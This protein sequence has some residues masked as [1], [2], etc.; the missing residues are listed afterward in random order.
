MVRPKSGMVAAMLFLAALAVAVLPSPSEV[1]V[2]M[3]LPKPSEFRSLGDDRFSDNGLILLR[4]TQKQKLGLATLEADQ[5]LPFDFSEVMPLAPSLVL[6]RGS[7]GW[8]LYDRDGE[9][10]AASSVDPKTDLE[11]VCYKVNDEAF[12][13]RTGDAEYAVYGR[14]GER[15]TKDYPSLRPFGDDSVSVLQNERIGV[16]DLKDQVVIPFEYTSVRVVGGKRCLARDAS[17][18]WGVLTLDGKTVLRF[19]YAGIG[20]LGRQRYVVANSAGETAVVTEA[21]DVIVGF[22]PRRFTGSNGDYIG[23]S[24]ADGTSSGIT[25]L[26]SGKMVFSGGSGTEGI[27]QLSDRFFV[28]SSKEVSTVSY[29]PSIKYKKLA[30]IDARKGSLTPMKYYDIRAVP[31]A[32]GLVFKLFDIEKKLQYYW[33][34]NEAGKMIAEKV[35]VGS[36]QDVGG[37]TLITTKSPGEVSDVT[38][39]QLTDYGAISYDGKPFFDFELSALLP[40]F[41]EGLAFVSSVRPTPRRGYIDASGTFKIENK[42]FQSGQ[43]FRG[44]TAVVRVGENFSDS[45]FGAIGKGGAFVIAPKFERLKRHPTRDDLFAADAGNGVWLLLD[46]QGSELHRAEASRI[47]FYGEDMFVVVGSG[48][49]EALM[50]LVGRPADLAHAQSSQ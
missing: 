31:S 41:S 29:N 27:Y 5:I 48:G 47:D 50:R 49:A 38:G 17:G 21:G 12:I 15:L 9:R 34:M 13:F 19:E 6:A 14:A 20:A 35:E 37:R 39:Y 32:D 24:S 2:V 40:E 22:A 4:D 11:E 3:R 46:R 1:E 45:R 23:W 43:P 33:L 18:K 16:V 25:D 36:V 42:D 30:L 10:V 26:Q 44:G 28:A 7:E 8:A